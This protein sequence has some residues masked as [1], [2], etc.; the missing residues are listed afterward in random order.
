MYQQQAQFH[1]TVS[2]SKYPQSFS[3]CPNWN[4]GENKTVPPYILSGLMNTVKGS[5]H[6]ADD[7]VLA[8]AAATMEGDEVQGTWIMSKLNSIRGTT[9]TCSHD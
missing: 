5:T 8:F 4:H 2:Y 6:L 3:S 7:S 1:G 9:A